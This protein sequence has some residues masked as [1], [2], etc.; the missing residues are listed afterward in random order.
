M[1]I[2]S[3]AMRHDVVTVAPEERVADALELAA[4]TAA[5]H[6]L[7]MDG[8]DLVGI[9]CVHDLA[10]A[11]ADALVSDEMTPIALVVRPDEPIEDAA[12]TMSDRDVPCAAVALGGLLLGTLS[13]A[14]VERACGRAGRAHARRRS[15]RGNMPHA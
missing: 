6:L 5:D 7:V 2:V 12:A 9:A 15:P 13:G 8:E 11:R 4:A 10:A 14:A 1:T 3:E